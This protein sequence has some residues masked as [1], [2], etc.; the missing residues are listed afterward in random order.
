MK[1]T[2]YH[3]CSRFSQSD[4]T[5]REYQ[6]GR[7]QYSTVAF[8]DEDEHDRRD[9]DRD[10]DRIGSG[11]VGVGAGSRD[12]VYYDNRPKTSGDLPSASI[13]HALQNSLRK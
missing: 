11:G 5:D 7:H 9:R 3:L 2:F 13:S 12:Q 1:A 4:P 10:R 8:Q 6:R